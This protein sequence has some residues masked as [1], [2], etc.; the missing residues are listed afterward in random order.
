MCEGA[1]LTEL[2]YPLQVEHAKL[3]LPELPVQTR[4]VVRLCFGVLCASLPERPC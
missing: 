4:T 1:V 2:A 3:G